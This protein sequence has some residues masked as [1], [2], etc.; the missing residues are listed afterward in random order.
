M[1][2]NS[3]SVR[4]WQP[5]SKSKEVECGCSGGEIGTLGGSQS[6]EDSPRTQEVRCMNWGEVT[7][8]MADI[9]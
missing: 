8:H 2:K 3:L 1:W 9:D 6:W 4:S 5:I 7:S